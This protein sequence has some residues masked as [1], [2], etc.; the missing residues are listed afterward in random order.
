M[1][2]RELESKNI[3]SQSYDYSNFSDNSNSHNC[4]RKKIAALIWALIGYT[5]QK[6]T[7]FKKEKHCL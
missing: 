3:F 6:T 5:P 4:T 1:Y 7:N 2:A